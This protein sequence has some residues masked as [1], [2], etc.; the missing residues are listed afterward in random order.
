LEGEF[1]GGIRSAF[2]SEYILKV[3]RAASVVAVVFDLGGFT[4]STATSA[5]AKIE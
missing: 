2:V 1:L 5:W 3:R 4:V